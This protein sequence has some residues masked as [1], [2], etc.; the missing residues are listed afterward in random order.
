[1]ESSKQ[2]SII[3]FFQ[4]KTNSE[5]QQKKTFSKEN[6]Q[7]T[8][9]RK[10]TENQQKKTTENQ[11]KIFSKENQQKTNKRKPTVKKKTNS[12]CFKLCLLKCVL[13][14]CT[15]SA[16]MT[17]LDLVVTFNCWFYCKFWAVI[18]ASLDLL[19]WFWACFMRTL[20]CIFNQHLATL[21]VFSHV[22]AECRHL[23]R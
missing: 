23:G 4:K 19:G 12:V 6:Q 20:G 1:M 21:G 9:K 2:Q 18:W 13:L 14:L 11:Q 15:Y 22:T 17:W 8:N 10:P 7:K 16:N 3:K 5:N